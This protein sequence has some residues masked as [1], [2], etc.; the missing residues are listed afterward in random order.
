RGGPV[1]FKKNYEGQFQ[2]PVL[3]PARLPFG[4]LNGSFGIPVGFSTRI[5]SHNLREVA[6][7]AAHV[8]K[9][10]RATVKEILGILPGPDFPGG[11]QIISARDEIRPAYET[12]RGSIAMRARWT[13]EQLARGQWR[14]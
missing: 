2:G 10:P 6:E 9:H 4:L 1:R 12:G 11:G 3:L 13:T 8:I 5:P 7:A 14:I